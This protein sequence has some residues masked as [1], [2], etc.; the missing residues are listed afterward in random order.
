MKRVTTT[1]A[2]AVV[3]AGAA[4]G[5]TLGSASSAHAQSVTLD[6][7]R[8]PATAEDGLVLSRP[9]DRGHL[10]VGA[11]L[12]LDYANGPLV[13]EPTPGSSAGEIAVVEHQLRAHVGVSLGLF[14]R[15][16]IYGGLPIDLVQEGDDML[17]AGIGAADGAGL[18]DAWL[19]ARVRLF[20]E[21]EDVLALG[22]DAN[23]TLPSATWSR[24]SQR[25]TG[26]RGVGIVPRLLGEVRLG[27]GFLITANV[28]ARFRLT[29]EARLQTLPVGQ[30][31]IWGLG[32]TLPIVNEAPTGGISLAALIEVFGAT[33][34]ERFGDRE[35]SPVEAQIGLRLEPICGLGVTLAGGPGLARGYGSPDVRGLLMI[36][37][38]DSH[39]TTP[40]APVPTP[41]PGPAD[42]DGDGILDPDD[43]CPNE[44]EDR[45]SF[46]DTDGCPDP[47]NDADG[48]LDP[49]DRCPTIAEDRDAFEDEDGCPDPD[50]DGDGILDPN[51]GC[52]IV[53]EDADGFEDSDG[54]PDPDND[55]D[56]VLDPQ[57]ECPLAPGRPEDRGCPRTIRYE[58]E[59]GT[60]VVLQRVEFATNRD[61][62]LDRSFPVLE[63][64]RAILAAN[65]NLVLVRVEGHTDDR[66][67]DAANLE[68]SRRRARSVVAWLASHGISPD[69]L[70][71]WGCGETAPMET[72]TTADGRQ[73]N[74]RVEFHVLT[75]APARGARSL[76]GCIQAP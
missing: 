37:W 56:T 28:G 44:P 39:C 20:G 33:T 3:L 70:E 63:E 52:P 43:R 19:G 57:D 65:P 38:S 42:T 66:G 48:I 23:V 54:C 16:V 74:R 4:T 30:E 45:D 13:Y 14:D 69:R 15:L 47:D 68:L 18:G 62:I 10:R 26:E 11:L 8:M 17:P 21:R 29:D 72:N 27:S 60:I 32:G 67:R 64:V 9:D 1:L 12:A 58:A 40:P 2:S 46:E 41:E 7:Y 49:N 51:D 73:V 75:P 6:Q 50:N 31:F 34:F 53:A 59:T 5:A 71:G 35:T 76:P 22:L 24:E 36:G 61:V 55:Q 25:Y